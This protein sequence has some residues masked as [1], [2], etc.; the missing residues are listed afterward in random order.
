MESPSKMAAILPRDQLHVS[1]YHGIA[2]RPVLNFPFLANLSYYKM[3]TVINNKC[4]IIIC[5][6][7]QFN[8][9]RCH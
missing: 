8:E 1:K 4:K 2:T 5:Y 6:T 3:D 7:Y 9:W